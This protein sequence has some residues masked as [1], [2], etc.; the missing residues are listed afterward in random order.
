M[1]AEFDQSPALNPIIALALLV[2]SAISELTD[3]LLLLA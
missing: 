2:S 3:L 1:A